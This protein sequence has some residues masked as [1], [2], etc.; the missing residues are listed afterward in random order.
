MSLPVARVEL[1]DDLPGNLPIV[2]L[3]REGELVLRARRKD[4]PERTAEAAERTLQY[5][6]DTGAITL[7]WPPSQARDDDGPH[8][9]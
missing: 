9:N 8:P 7:N 3:Q 1:V 4:L 6:L 2:P 5:M